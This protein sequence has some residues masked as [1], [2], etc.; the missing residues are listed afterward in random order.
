MEIGNQ[1]LPLAWFQA[2]RERQEMALVVF[3][4]Q[5]FYALQFFVSSHKRDFRRKNRFRKGIG[6]KFKKLQSF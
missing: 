2:I 5:F 1:I 3:S 4:Q 6:K